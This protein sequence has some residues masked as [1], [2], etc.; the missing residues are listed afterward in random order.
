MIDDI[1]LNKKESVERCVRQIR[2]YYA[3]PSDL[4]FEEDFLKQ[5]AIAIN[6]QRA[7]EQCID[8]ANH[9]VRLKKLGI[10]KDSK[11]SFSF[12]AKAKIIPQAL[13]KQLEGMVGFRN[14]LVHEYQEVEIKIMEDVI[15]N[16]LDDLIDFTVFIMEA[17]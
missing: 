7:A 1:V 16:H 13:A 4:P 2:L 8:L 15:E 6:L 14:T 17:D 3:K 9:L 10:P 12:L 5:D 11:E